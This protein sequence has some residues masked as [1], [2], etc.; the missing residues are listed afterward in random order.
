MS[1]S[2][3]DDNGARTDVP[4]TFVSFCVQTA[5]APHI[6]SQELKAPGRN[7]VWLRAP[8]DGDGCPSFP[9]LN[10]SFTRL[11]R[12]IQAGKVTAAYA[13][14]PWGNAAA[15][16]KMALGNGIGAE[17]RGGE[18]FRAE[19]GSFLLE[20]PGE[21]EEELAG[22]Q[23]E[24]LGKTITEPELIINGV[25][26]PLEDCRRA[27]L[28]P[29]EG[30]FPTGLLEPEPK[31][32]P[33]IPYTNC[34]AVKKSAAKHAKPTVCM[35]LFPGTS[36][37]YETARAFTEAGGRV[38]EYVLR[39]VTGLGESLKELEREIRNA[40]ILALPGGAGAGDEP[41]G[42]GKYTAVILRNPRI[43]DAVMDLLARD[44]LILGI[45][46]GFQGLLCA[47]L[48]PYGEVRLPSPASPV[49]AANASGNFVS[50][51]VRVKVTSNLSPWMYNTQ[52]G[53][54]YL[55][56]VAHGRGRFMAADEVMD[57]LVRGGQI[58]ARYVDFEGNA[59]ADIRY[60]PGGCPQAGVE[61][62]TSPD[63]RILGR[64]GHLERT[65]KGLYKGFD[66]PMEQGLFKAGV[67]YFT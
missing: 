13:L 58:A 55:L 43:S 36:G 54:V 30:V 22:L 25:T 16:T 2:Y 48:L 63:G 50:D 9:Y 38:K 7:L 21:P 27:W 6:I 34:P 66:M 42:A 45:G 12:L 57:E 11:N 29:L 28:S 49:L 23:Y 17:V 40:Q 51:L 41:G 47:G 59:T 67:A 18:W 61:A 62:L 5:K 56:P 52:P 65:G 60:N 37:E 64:M 33:E 31:P 39:T 14:G 26:I 19:T 35:P 10:E 15:L 32:L 53:E 46:N 24:A 4:P 8:Y 20:M 44:G 1:G 3:E